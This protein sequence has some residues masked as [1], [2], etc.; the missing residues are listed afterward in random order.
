MILGK[1]MDIIVHSITL[2]GVQPIPIKVEINIERNITKR[3]GTFTIIGMASQSIKESSK[4]IVAVLKL[5]NVNMAENYNIT[6]NLSPADVKKEGSLLDLPIALAILK[7]VGKIKLPDSFLKETYIAGEMALDGEIHPIKAAIPLACE[8]IKQQ[9]K[10]I[11]IP[12]INTAEVSS[13]QGIK[14]YGIKHIKEFN[15]SQPI[16]YNRIQYKDTL[17]TIDFDDVK[18]QEYAKRALQIAVAGNHNLIF[19]GPPGAGK[20]MLAKR[21]VTIMPR[22]SFEETLE[23]TKIYSIAG[24]LKHHSLLVNRP[25]RA[26]HHTTP[27]ASLIGGGI[28][29]MPGEITLAHNG[30]LFLDEITEFK[31]DVIECLREPIENKSIN[32]TRSHQNITFPTS[33]LLIAACNPCPCGYFGDE[34]KE[35]LC[36]PTALKMY[37]NKLSGPLLDRIDIRIGIKA[38]EY[39]DAIKRLTPTPLCSANL[40]KGVQ[41]AMEKQKER[42]NQEGV[43]N[44]N[45]SS[46]EVD[47]YC[48]LTPAAQ[49]LIKKAF[50]KLSLSM[51]AFHKVL[52]LARTIADMDDQE[53]IDVKHIS[54]ALMYKFETE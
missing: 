38:L 35:C 17:H 48:V 46:N 25:F 1:S 43:F 24:K 36:P 11:I 6:V 54:E 23:T 39:E 29:P 15:I 52:K 16:S 8:A 45:M 5:L 10:N 47:K 3:S 53:I 40:K 50:K 41:K 22:M 13:F 30:V 37:Q 51:R 21:I 19:T 26:P 34:K 33:F 9:K 28:N 31:K 49:E 44:A 20:S 32:I 12:H 7:G 42:F 18:G 2:L 4:R 27:K 14:V